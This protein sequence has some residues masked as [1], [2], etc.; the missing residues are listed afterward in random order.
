ML[1]IEKYQRMTENKAINSPR[2]LHDHSKHHIKIKQRRKHYAN[3][4]NYRL[5]EEG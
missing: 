1:L 4:R 3:V 5:R 2:E